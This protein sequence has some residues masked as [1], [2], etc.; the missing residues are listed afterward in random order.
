[1]ALPASVIINS[2]AVVGQINPRVYGHFI[3]H[4]ESCLYGGIWTADGRQMRQDT[5]AL[6]RPLRPPVVRYPG[7]N[8]ASGYHWED[9]IGPRES[10][11]TTRASP[12]SC[13]SFAR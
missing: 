5:L 2:I 1:M 12:P 8:F 10:R 13:A 6:I 3:E 7:G 9:G 4:L 11:P